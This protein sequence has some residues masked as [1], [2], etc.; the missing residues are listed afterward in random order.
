[1]QSIDEDAVVKTSFL[2]K[3]IRY[4]VAGMFF[5]VFAVELFAYIEPWLFPLHMIQGNA[6]HVTANII[7]GP[8]PTAPE[9]A[10]LK[11]R[12]HVVEVISLLSSSIPLDSPMLAKERRAV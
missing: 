3:A 4:I 5:F 2:P 11:E 10:R 9:L 12:E 6:R 1:M 8:Y 7:V